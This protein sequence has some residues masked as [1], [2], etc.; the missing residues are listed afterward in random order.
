MDAPFA[1]APE[2]P[3]LL[4][5]DDMPANLHVLAA[6]LKS[7][8]RL[9]TATGGADALA[10]ADREDDRPDM[11][12]LDVMMPGMSG[13]EVLRH[14]RDKVETRDIPV[15]FVSADTSEQSQLDG[16]ELGA[17]DYLT[18]P[19]VG[20]VLRAR[21]KNLLARKRTERQLRLAAHVFEYSGEAIM[22]T[23]RD[24]RIVEVN[25]AF[26]RL[27][28][29]TLDEVRGHNPR[30]LSS[31]RCTPEQY[32][33]MWQAIVEDGMWQGEM[34]DRH[35]DG[36]VY[37][38]LI[39]ISTVKN[40]RGEI[41][42]HIANF[43]NI[44]DQK[45]AEA[46]IR[47]VAYH[48]ALTGLPNRTHLTIA[49]EQA[50]A[51][52]RRAEAEIALM[53]IDMD[54]FKNINDTLGHHVGDEM[55]VEVARRL[56]E[57]VRESDIVARLGGD[58]FVVA[59]AGM[60]AAG[61]ATGVAGKLLDALARPYEIA[62]HV[63]HSSPSI[64]ISVYPADG[65]DIATLMK[66]A[67]TAMY[68]AK[69]QGRNNAQYFTAAMNATARSRLETEHD[70]RGALA[71]GQFELHYQPQVHAA[72]GRICCVEA[73]VRWRHPRRGLVSP[74]DFIPIA[75]ETGLIE[76]IG[77]WVLDEAC[78][79]LA[80]WRAS[81]IDELA[82]A[83]NLSAHQLRSPQLVDT[84]RAVLARHALREGDIELEV[85]ESV[86]MTHPER[87]IDQL[88]ALRA[89]GV[90]LAIDDFGTGY[91]SLAYLKNL[92]IQ[93]L[94]LDRS[95]VRDIETDGN[96]AAICAATIALA[97]SLGLKVVAEGVETPAQQCFLTNV[98]HCDLLQGYLF[99]KPMPAAE[100][101][102]LL[103]RAPVVA[104]CAT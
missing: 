12:L 83:I 99:G 101:A 10:L 17:D 21:V 66:N 42:F 28:G 81:G 55:L 102:A 69:E 58:E 88:R 76:P 82:M 75:E 61:A 72:S 79:Q 91:S 37:P 6:A 77:A 89:L 74:L 39:T 35:K 57:C 38:K 48:D 84:V 73:L 41:D 85:T 23:D 90:R 8:Y 104:A 86:A 50:L 1:A 98:H 70:L 62:G 67:D 18:K 43:S 29:Y 87:A 94:K 51:D 14:L 53:F 59:L 9:K 65:A 33:A 54:R 2:K 97:H 20:T 19:V 45:E 60:T 96:D 103:R 15:I 68:H 95:F 49:L 40:R 11:I 93:A 80:A 63:L 7:D 27:T 71:A 5:V 31:G 64:G 46:R 22:I 13:I 24:N 52:A 3:L 16:L 100:L 78:R 47:H 4:L 34:W 26:T 32:R 36:G 92:P 25:P 30:L 56:K 44:S